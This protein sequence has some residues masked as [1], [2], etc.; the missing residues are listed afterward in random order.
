MVVVR[1]STEIRHVPGRGVAAD[2]G[3]CYHTIGLSTA[4]VPVPAYLHTRDVRT[5]SG[6]PR[7]GD[8]HASNSLGE[9]L[10]PTLCAV[11]PSRNHYSAL[12]TI[13][14]T[15][16]A[17]GLKVFIIDDASDEPARSSIAALHAPSQGIEVTRLAENQGKGGAV[18]AGLRRAFECG[19]T[20][21]VQVDADGQHDLR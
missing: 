10:E 17:H 16:S 8:R 14:A 21:A 18:A 19:F 1:P 2:G 6:L 20:H 7:R 9:Y 4:W 13:C 12:G 3:N 15:L 11:V 5:S